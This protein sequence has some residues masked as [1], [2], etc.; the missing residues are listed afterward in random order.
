MIKKYYLMLVLL[1]MG[2]NLAAADQNND[3]AMAL[4]L[5]RQ[6]MQDDGDRKAAMAIQ[7]EED[8]KM[9]MQ[10]DG[11]IEKA[12]SL[13]ESKNSQIHEIEFSDDPD[14]QY[15]LIKEAINNGK[16]PNSI[17]IKRL[18]YP[19]SSSYNAWCSGCVLHEGWHDEINWNTERLYYLFKNGARFDKDSNWNTLLDSNLINR[20][21]L[22]KQNNFVSPEVPI[23]YVL[24]EANPKQLLLDLYLGTNRQLLITKN[25]TALLEL[26]NYLGGVGL[27]YR[28]K[29]SIPEI[30]NRF[31]VLSSLFIRVGFPVD[32]MCKLPSLSP[33]KEKTFEQ[34]LKLLQ[35]KLNLKKCKTQK[36]ARKINKERQTAF[37][38]A[39][40]KIEKAKKEVAQTQIGVKNLLA[41]EHHLRVPAVARIVEGY[42]DNDV[43][44]N[45]LAAEMEALKIELDAGV[46]QL[47]TQYQAEIRAE[48][49]RKKQIERVHDQEAFARMNKLL[50]LSDLPKGDMILDLNH[51]F[52]LDP[53]F[54]DCVAP[55]SNGRSQSSSSNADWMRANS[56]SQSSSLH[57]GLS[58]SS[59]NELNNSNGS[60]SSSSNAEWM[61][62][63]SAS[64]S[65]SSS[66]VP[67]GK[68]EKRKL[69]E[70]DNRDNA[71][72]ARTENGNSNSSSANASNSSSS[73]TNTKK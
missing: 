59:H 7:M 67:N 56:A 12:V 65:S 1:L 64:Q 21:L 68:G 34:S 13:K 16:H 61:R 15:D 23:N 37:D 31:G 33:A 42:L 17:K 28:A 54:A 14:K 58:S 60:Q 46:A 4:E 11:E 25:R 36:N 26:V 39:L 73:A 66:D 62:A 41:D 8:S 43:L 2:L 38:N 3:E 72:R 69:D 40:K 32:Q 44:C 35:N 47:E 29:G 48:Q 24:Y 55:F 30:L 50:E 71:K 53:E 19:F 22:I 45:S 9:A 20:Y 52:D 27:S 6:G 18:G 5:A 70:D 51:N 49:E 57:N 10:G 63:N